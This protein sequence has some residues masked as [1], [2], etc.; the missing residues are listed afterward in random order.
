MHTLALVGSVK[1]AV[2]TEG[3][4]VSYPS[5]FLMLPFRLIGME[6]TMT[7]KREFRSGGS[8]FTCL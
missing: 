6:C 7:L 4:H 8:T 5:V 1:F 3:V 2:E